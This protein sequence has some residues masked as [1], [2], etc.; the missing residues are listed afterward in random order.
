[1][2]TPL[3]QS[4]SQGHAELS[5]MAVVR[6]NF[7]RLTPKQRAEAATASLETDKV[8]FGTIVRGSNT[9][10]RQLRISNTGHTPLEIRRTYSLQPGVEATASV[11]KLK[12]G[13]STAITITVDPS[14]IAP[15]DHMLNARLDIIT[16]DPTSP[17]QTVRVVGLVANQ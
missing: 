8:D 6:E 7:D 12:P 10:T 2:A 1:M 5:V 9:A 14:K 11:Q 15:D 16:N 17:V 3:R 4:G 13:K